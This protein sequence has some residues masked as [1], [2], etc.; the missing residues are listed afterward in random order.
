MR[1]WRHLLSD[2]EKSDH[3]IGPHR[4]SFFFFFF[5]SFSS[6]QPVPPEVCVCVTDD[7]HVHVRSH[8]RA[9][10][11]K[12]RERQMESLY[13]LLRPCTIQG[14]RTYACTCHF[15]WVNHVTSFWN[16]F[17]SLIRYLLSL[18]E[19]RFKHMGIDSFLPNNSLAIFLFSRF[20]F[21]SN[22]LQIEFTSN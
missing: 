16:V 19:E 15:A 4:S 9:C 2:E 18:V 12:K 11:E 21:I 14:Q 13:C 3:F 20:I 8:Q 22:D 1:R 6:R 7:F 5:S 10:D 17:F